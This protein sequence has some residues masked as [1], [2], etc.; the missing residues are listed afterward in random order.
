[1]GRQ[2]FI[3]SGR[4][5]CLNDVH[6]QKVALHRAP[7]VR[8]CG[9]S[10]SLLQCCGISCL[11]ILTPVACH[12]Q[13]PDSVPACFIR[14]PRIASDVADMI[15]P[16]GHGRPDEMWII[17]V[18]SVNHGCLNRWRVAICTERKCAL[19]AMA[20]L[21]WPCTA[22]KACQFPAAVSDRSMKLLRD[23]YPSCLSVK[24]LPR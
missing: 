9:S 1:M 13:P 16:P 23:R 3:Q 17:G 21:L 7:T 22:H 14:L 4:T 24:F 19:T 15:G 12:D 8:P 5:Q 20:S 6:C 2:N 18:S 10:V 11:L